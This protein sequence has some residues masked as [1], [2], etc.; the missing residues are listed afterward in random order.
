MSIHLRLNLQGLDRVGPKTASEVVVLMRHVMGPLVGEAGKV[1]VITL[2]P[3][4][5]DLNLDFDSDSNT[6][7]SG[8]CAGGISILGEDGG[9]EVFVRA[10]RDLRICGPIDPRTKRKDTRKFLTAS[11]LLGPALANTG[12][13]ELG[14]FIAD[15]PH[16]DDAA[17][18]M[19]FFGPPVKERTLATQREFWA[20]KKIFTTDQRQ[21]LVKQIRDGKWLLD[22][23]FGP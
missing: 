19:N 13:H 5:G 9:Q 22:M 4:Q 1:L 17:N 23:T 7:S 16:V 2:G 11:W 21:R 14:H 15:L 20:G 3:H 10:H 18:F 12:I 8:I 6:S